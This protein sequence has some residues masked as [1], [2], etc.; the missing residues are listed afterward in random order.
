ES[1]VNFRAPFKMLQYITLVLDKYE[2]E[3][4]REHPGLTSTRDFRY[5]PVLPLIFYDGPAPWTAARNF[6]DRTAL[7]DV[8]GDYIP[9]FKYELVELNKYGFEDL[10][11]YRD[12]LSLLLLVDR[13]QKREELEELKG[14]PG[15]YWEGVAL[16][17]PEG[18]VKLV[19]DV[20]T[21]LLERLE[22]PAEEIEAVKE[23][24]GKKEYQTMFD[25]L[26]ES[27]LEDKRLAREEGIKIGTQ[28]GREEGR[29]EGREEGIQIG[30]EAKQ[31][32]AYREKLESAR[33]LK[34]Y[35]VSV[36]VIAQSLHLTMEEVESL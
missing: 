2:K 19:K 6:A 22:V 27:V 13:I 20:I 34:G 25:A 26:V 1:Q 24:V 35:G 10:S 8:F 16:N 33:L 17:I 9:S 18:M 3:V 21:V 14:L 23:H 32:E 15:D 11:R 4:N 7:K 31:A 30:S 29:D 28:K 12:A 36:E 5:P